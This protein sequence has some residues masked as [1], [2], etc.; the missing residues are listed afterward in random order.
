MLPYVGVFI[1]YIKTVNLPTFC[2]EGVMLALVDE[3]RMAMTKISAFCGSI[4][5]GGIVCIKNAHL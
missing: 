2:I 4:T 5:E 3:I 1:L